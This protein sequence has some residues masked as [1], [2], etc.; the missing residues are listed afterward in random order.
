MSKTNWAFQTIYRY[1]RRNMAYTNI[2]VRLLQSGSW[3]V[4]RMDPTV[5]LTNPDDR[6]SYGFV[7]SA[8][9]GTTYLASS[10]RGIN[11]SCAT[12]KISFD[13]G[14]NY[15]AG[16]NLKIDYISNGENNWDYGVFSKSG[17]TIAT[18]TTGGSS[19]YKSCKGESSTS[20]KTLYYYIPNNGN[21]GSIY[22]NYIKDGSG[23]EGLDRLYLDISAE[24]YNP[25]YWF[26]G[27]KFEFKGYQSATDG[28]YTLGSSV[29]RYIT[30]GW[31]G[32][33]SGVRSATTGNYISYW[34][35]GLTSD[36]PCGDDKSFELK[37][38]AY[39]HM[40]ANTQEKATVVTG[41]TATS[42][43]KNPT[44]SDIA[45]STVYVQ[46]LLWKFGY[47]D[48]AMMGDYRFSH[49]N[50]ELKEG[51]KT[52]T[53][54][55][56]NAGMAFVYSSAFTDST[57]NKTVTVS[58]PGGLQTTNGQWY[59]NDAS[60][61]TFW[62][63]GRSGAMQQIAAYDGNGYIVSCPG[64]T[65]GGQVA[66]WTFIH[67][68]IDSSLSVSYPRRAIRWTDRPSKFVFDDDN[69]TPSSNEYLC[70]PYIMKFNNTGATYFNDLPASIN[71]W[72]GNT[73]YVIGYYNYKNNG[74]PYQEL[75][76]ES[77]IGTGGESLDDSGLWGFA[78]HLR[79]PR[80]TVSPGNQGYGGNE[81]L[82]YEDCTVIVDVPAISC[83]AS[84]GKD[85]ETVASTDTDETYAS[86]S[87]YVMSGTSFWN[88]GD[89]RVH[90]EIGICEYYDEGA[91]ASDLDSDSC[92]TT[93]EVNMIE[94][95]NKI[96]F[97]A[98]A[99]RAY[100]LIF[101][102]EAYWK[103][104]IDTSYGVNWHGNLSLTVDYR[105]EEGSYMYKIIGD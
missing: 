99:G 103:G 38:S 89:G 9:G 25:K 67:D 102:A 56:G 59:A 92:G 47:W 87:I 33:D 28:A 26:I 18:G 73:S 95:T 20:V 14:A 10:N 44:G 78:W 32:L 69:Y 77:E 53:A 86:A 54:K 91:I 43:R 70:L 27:H 57:S 101:S 35:S 90:D 48:G 42:V 49:V 34:S 37:V 40:S 13:F 71:K 62:G 19:V 6:S 51:T 96:T 21:D 17:M 85:C 98:L 52:V 39:G 1:K 82:M 23:H 97:R 94:S 12:A 72:S 5:Y 4:S 46:Q 2:T 41:T 79:D 55:T 36:A 104:S 81:G 88:L 83:F 31:P 24:Y 11:N 105:I 7:L 22:I 15:Y 93:D 74:N 64:P 60:H 63:Y 8:Y 80:T 75:Y 68:N 30:S 45:F 61:A 84:L 65:N 100:G 76:A 66:T 58:R 3:R 50:F 29:G 16:I